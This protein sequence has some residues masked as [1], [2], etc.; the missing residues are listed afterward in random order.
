MSID[1]S[2]LRAFIEELTGQASPLQ[3][4]V[5]A[6]IIAVSLSLAWLL[7]KRFCGRFHVSPRW[8][9]GAGEFQRVMFPLMALALVWTSKLAMEHVT[10]P[11]TL[12]GIA[13]SLLI[14]WLAI[15]IAVYILGHVLPEGATLRL[16]VR[17][18]AWVAWIAVALHITGLMPE[19]LDAL[20]EIGFTVGK[21]KTHVSLLLILQAISA[22]AVTLTVALW[23]AR[24]TEGRVLAA[25]NVEMNTRVVIVKIVN[26]AA[27]IVA[28]MVA[29]PMAGIDITALS[30]FGGAV[31]VG[32]GFGL[33][34][35][36]SNYVSGFIVLLERSLRIGDVITIDNRRGVVQ[37]IESRYTVIKAGDG[38][39]T[40]IPNEDL[41]TKQVVHHTYTDPKVATVLAVT[42]SY[43]TDA[44]AACEALAEVGKRNAR[45]IGDPS[46]QAR[47]VGLGE[48]GI[49]MELTVWIDDPEKGES[50][51]RSELLKDILRTFAEKRIQVA[52][53]RREIHLIPTPETGKSVETTAG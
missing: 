29:L 36:A 2:P 21:N 9:F 51:L 42:V 47:V 22:M 28:I 26:T 52:S 32:L 48:N 23:L 31:G 25:Q 14:A 45:V 18:I 16:I 13:N 24:V 49:Q 38:T 1:I 4:A 30:V 46:P 40:I 43:G 44:E 8:K 10:Q 50:D 53:P 17:I 19:V 11:V 33:Q 3:W 12:L 41:I 15:R 39:E 5:Q 35:V 27:V 6:A 20:D 7:S 37:A 34:K